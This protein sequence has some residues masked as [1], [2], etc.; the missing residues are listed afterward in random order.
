MG[1]RVAVELCA[2]ISD[3]DGREQILF[4]HYHVSGVEHG[5]QRE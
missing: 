2:G 5:N 3:H 1:P 4:E